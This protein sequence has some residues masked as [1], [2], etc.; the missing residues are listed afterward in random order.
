SVHRHAN[1][2]GHY[3]RLYKQKEITALP[4]PTDEDG[5]FFLVIA[6]S[7]RSAAL[8]AACSCL[9]SVCGAQLFYFMKYLLIVYK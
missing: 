7:V 2:D 4:R 8:L 1:I 9:L 3:R 5:Y 6:N